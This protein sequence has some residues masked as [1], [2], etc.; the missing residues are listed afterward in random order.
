MRYEDSEDGWDL[1]DREEQGVV[2][3]EVTRHPTQI[4]FEGSENGVHAGVEAGQ[5]SAIC[6][7]GCC[8][9]ANSRNVLGSPRWEREAKLIS[10]CLLRRKLGRR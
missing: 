5:R 6:K 8:Y 3:T 1:E 9:G 2:N 7:P 4:R 10:V